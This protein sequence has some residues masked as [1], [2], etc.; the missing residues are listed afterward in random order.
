[1]S[2]ETL[3]DTAASRERL[4]YTLAFSDVW[5]AESRINGEPDSATGFEKRSLAG[6]VAWSTLERTWTVKLTWNHTIKK[7]SWGENFPASDIYSVGVSRVF[8]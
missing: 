2:Y 6:T 5:E 7:N 3:F 1:M 8:F 4:T